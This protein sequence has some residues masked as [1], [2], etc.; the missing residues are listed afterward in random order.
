M[1][2]SDDRGEELHYAPRKSTIAPNVSPPTMWGIGTYDHPLKTL[3]MKR[4]REEEDE[5][6]RRGGEDGTTQDRAPTFHSFGVFEPTRKKGGK[7]GDR[8]N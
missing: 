8:P 5:Q 4:S 2:R 1:K 3:N 6:M 7:S